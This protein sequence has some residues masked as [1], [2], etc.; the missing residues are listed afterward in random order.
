MGLT[1]R[2]F[3]FANATSHQE[4][5]MAIGATATAFEARFEKYLP[6]VV[7]AICAGLQNTGATDVCN[8]CVGALSSIVAALTVRPAAL[9]APQPNGAPSVC[10]TFIT[11]LMHALQDTTIERS[12]KPPVISAF[13]DIA[14][15]IG[16]PFEKYMQVV[17]TMLHSAAHSP[18]SDE[19][20]EEVEYK[21]MLWTSIID[22]YC[23]I[24]NGF[25]VNPANAPVVAQY[26]PNI[27][28]CAQMVAT[29]EFVKDVM[30]KEVLGLLG[31][32]CKL[33]PDACKPFVAQMTPWLQPY[34]AEALQDEDAQENAQ[35]A[36]VWLQKLG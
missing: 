29:D 32:A 35:Y 10:D 12:V 15:A 31:D 7:P 24:F 3:E 9:T 27:L 1:M 13:G 19:D 30:N 5:F 28:Q 14:L 36:Q 8:T 25:A 33:M 23:G 16:Q 6:A 2:G 22:A 18:L 20:E 34:L 4:C 11:L 17:G 21:Q 26:L